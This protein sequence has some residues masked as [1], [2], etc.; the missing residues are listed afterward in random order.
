MTRSEV[1]ITKLRAQKR[2]S[3][4]AIHLPDARPKDERPAHS[5]KSNNFRALAVKHQ[6]NT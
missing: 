3:L 6:E 4:K 1:I 2:R 5:T